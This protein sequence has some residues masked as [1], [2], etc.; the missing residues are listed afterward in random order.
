MTRKHFEELAA[1]VR[2]STQPSSIERITVAEELAE[3]C[4]TQN[5]R[6]DRGRFFEACGLGEKGR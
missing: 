2:R 5:P 3:F 4:A 1:I 6:F